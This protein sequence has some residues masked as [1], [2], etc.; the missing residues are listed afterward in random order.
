MCLG[1]SQKIIYL[2]VFLKCG[3][4]ENVVDVGGCGS[5]GAFADVYICLELSPEPS[6]GRAETVLSCFSF[7]LAP[8]S[9]KN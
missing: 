3:G 9:T 7:P 4:L 2:G 8:P 6:A 1:C 5:E